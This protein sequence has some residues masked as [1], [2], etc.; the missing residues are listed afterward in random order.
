LILNIHPEKKHFSEAFTVIPLHGNPLSLVFLFIDENKLN[1][2]AFS[3]M[4]DAVDLSLKKSEVEEF[5]VS[6]L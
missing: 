2:K 3:F 5:R 4:R 6:K 1:F